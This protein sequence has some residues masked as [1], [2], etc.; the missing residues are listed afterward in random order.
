MRRGYWLLA[1]LLGGCGMGPDEDAIRQLVQARLQAELGQDLV[2]PV[3][4]RVEEKKETQEGL[5]RV[6]VHYRLR[7][8][9]D[10]DDLAAAHSEDLVYDSDGK[11]QHTLPLMGLESRYGVF[12]VGQIQDEQADLWLVSTKQGWRLAEPVAQP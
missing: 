3:E 2:E 8:L 1:L 4:F 6:K 5:Y 11:F 10:F 12:H 7:F 9:K